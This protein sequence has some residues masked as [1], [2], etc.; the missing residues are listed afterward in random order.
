MGIPASQQL[1]ETPSSHGP[2]RTNRRQ[3][4]LAISPRSWASWTSSIVGGRGRSLRWCQPQPR[5]A[6]LR[7]AGCRESCSPRS[8]PHSAA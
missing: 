4:V 3:L 7:R 8:F 6:R 5:Q 2:P 1:G